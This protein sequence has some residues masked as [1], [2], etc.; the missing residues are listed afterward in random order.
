MKK[1]N[2]MHKHLNKKIRKGHR[3][4]GMRLFFIIVVMVE[5]LAVV[6]VAWLVAWLLQRGFG[7]SFE[8]PL[9]GWLIV[10]SV[11]IGGAV[12]TVLSYAFFVPITR[13]SQAMQKV[14]KG[15]FSIRLDE[16][17]SFPELQ[18]IYSSFNIMTKEL[19][20]TEI[21]QT[22]FVSNVSHEFKTPINAIEGYATLLH[23]DDQLTVDERVVYA[24]KILFNT[25]RLSN[26]VGNILLLSKVDNQSI[27]SHRTTF[28]LD[29]QIR[30]S[31]VGLEA[32][33]DRK[34]IEFDVELDRIDYTG[35]E[36]LLMHVWN[37]LLGNAI[38]FDPDG[39]WIGLRLEQTD[40]GAV[41]TIEDNGPGIEHDALSHV[42]DRFYQS[43]SSHKQE[44]NGLGLA[45]VRQ[46]VTL[47]HGEVAVEN[48]LEGGCRFTVV[49][50]M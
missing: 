7:I 43:D 33:W 41:F 9:L 44:G 15:D 37:N 35:S 16:D 1:S 23:G 21:L 34:N 12:S 22:D 14:S 11:V 28:R 27:Q 8:L 26:L 38:K 19:E 30:Q 29:E 42:F 31:I 4:I 32:E 10:L 20:A 48:R 2:N 3:L 25:R 24:E 5:L 13:L 47:H 40:A 45:L 18:E 46:I 50:P 36:T 39:G 6:G 17:Q 49:L